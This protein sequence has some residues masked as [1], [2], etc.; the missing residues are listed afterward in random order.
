MHNVALWLPV[1]SRKIPTL[2]VLRVW[3]DGLYLLRMSP[4][5]SPRT[6]ASLAPTTRAGADPR[7]RDP[8]PAL[9]PR[10][11]AEVI[12]LWPS[13]SAL[14]AL[15]DVE[16]VTVRA[17]RRRG[18]PARYWSHV[19]RAARGTGRPVDERRLAEI[20]SVRGGSRHG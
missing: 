4:S 12:A 1:C 3:R 20:A 6:A 16:A 5:A 15:L 10:S 18:I 13:A 8:A 2:Q 9:P 11:F 19:A 7:H 14:A 17:W